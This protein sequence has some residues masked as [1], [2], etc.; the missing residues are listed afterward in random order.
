MQRGIVFNIQK[1]SIHDGPGTRTLVFLKGCT[2]RCQWCSN[3]ESM[4]PQ[5]ELFF[6]ESSC[7]HCGL[8]VAACP[9]AVHSMT[10]NAGDAA[11]RHV[12]DR[13]APCMQCHAC[14]DAC[15]HQALRL[16][17][18][19]MTVEEVVEVVLQDL[20]FYQ[21]SGGGVTLSGGEA[22]LQTDF[23]REILQECQG[24]GVHTALETCGQ[25]R[26][27]MLEALYRHVDLFLFDIKHL[28]SAAH[29]LYTGSTNEAILDNL[30]K[31]LE[32]GCTVSIRVP[33]IP[34]VNDSPEHV[35]RILQ[36]AQT[37]LQK[38]AAIAS[39]EFLPY[40]KYGSAKYNQLGRNFPLEDLP[41]HEPAALEALE[42]CMAGY[43]LGGV[44]VR[45]VRM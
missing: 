23:C 13:Q 10:V 5:P 20:P 40:H 44:P 37:Y 6:N 45:M 24:N 32:A 12:V 17:G 7:V 2:L 34:Q 21:T 43:D 29:R 18:Q 14:V 11:P 1:Y 19:E 35:G 33:L 3:P 16:V 30:H 39:V 36:L 41:T 42:A 15:L 31:L 25:V 28:D 27:E 26:W 8:C 38:G 4:S 22:A 9:K